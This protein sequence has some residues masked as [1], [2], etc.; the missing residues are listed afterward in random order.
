MAHVAIPEDQ[1]RVGFDHLERVFTL[2]RFGHL[3]RDR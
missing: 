3:E 2:A 1:C